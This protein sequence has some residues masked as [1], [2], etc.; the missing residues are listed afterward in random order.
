M[1]YD[2]NCL[3]G[4][5]EVTL[6]FGRRRRI[7]DLWRDFEDQRAVVAADEE[8][9]SP[10]ELFTTNDAETV[11]E[12]T[13][14]TGDTVE[15]TADHPFATPSGMCDLDEV[16]RGDSVFVHPF[17]GVADEEPPEFVVLDEDDFADEN[18]QLVRG[19]EE[20]DLLP[21][22]S[23][24]DAF[25]RLLKLVGFHTGDGSF[26]SN[27]SWFYGDPEDLETVAADIEAVGY[28]ASR[29]Y[30][31]DRE[32]EIDGRSFERT[33]YS[34]RATAKGFKRLLTK[35]G[36][37]AGRKTESDF[38][39]PGYLD[40]LA[41]WQKALY[42]SAFF[43]AEMS[44]PD[45]MTAKNLYCPSVSHNR[46]VE[47]AAAGEAFVS[48][49]MRHLN[50]LGVRTN[51]L[52]TVERTETTRGETVR[53]RFGVK[54]DS[55]NLIRFFTRVGYRYNRVK[56][57]RA[58]L[59]AQYL[60]RKE[61]VVDE[62]ARLAEEARALADGG[63]A[64]REVKSRLDGVNGRFVERSIYGQREGRPRPPADFPDFE[65][66]AAETRVRPNFTVETTVES[67]TELGEKPVYDIGV[68]HDAH[69]F[70]ADGFVV[71][72]CG[73]RMVRT[74]L[75]Y[76]DVRGK[77]EELVDSLFANVPSGL[78]GGGV[79]EGNMD[80]VEAVLDRGMDWALEHGYAVDDDL[81]HCEDE[82]RRPD[83]RPE[84]VSEKAKN[85]GKNQIGS[86]GSGNHFLEVQR[87][88][89]VFDESVAGAFGLE[90]EQIV[91]LIH[92]GSRGLGHQVC[93][94]YLRRIEREH[95]DLLDRLPDKE[96][97]AAPAGSELAD[98]YYGAMCA[99]IN[100]A[101]VNRQLITHRTRRVF[102]RV[103]AEEWEDLGM[104]LLYDVAHNI[105]KKEVH[106]VDGE[107]RELYVHRK[108]ATRAFPAGRQEVPRAYRDVGQPVI[109]PGSMGAGSYVLVGGERSM[110]ETFGSTAHG[111]GRT[112][113]R[114]QAKQEYWGETVRD[115]LES[116]NAIYVKA[117]SGAT[118]AEEAPGVYKDVD[119]VV[120]VSD[121][122]GIGDKVV[123]TYPVCNI[124]G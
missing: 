119:E 121:E 41:D 84:F 79:V 56:R 44:A 65:A 88:T 12:V 5:S 53:Y 27:Q 11:F 74:D 32:H 60:K 97:A 52:E 108:G 81:A 24:D 10:V 2:I 99:A 69:N 51:A 55:E 45:A 113:S 59:A 39:V 66:F 122:L 116:Q 14:E 102:E 94:D 7:G 76:D 29:I 46:A 35:L 43:G 70:V 34:V 57:E 16:E 31:R 50:D 40:R 49:L 110:S 91:V 104:D 26:G 25:H 71:S 64:L 33:E 58:V 67:V 18:P 120:R 4:E 17:V 85:R 92:C 73:V 117:Q 28:T 111:A 77:E 82:G 106:T 95:G 63:L 20:R 96:L 3:S 61:R 54:N 37:P 80:T 6:E 72:N 93:S 87:V 62:R 30:E 112:M 90:E 78:G 101:W 115:E 15:A 103:F 83:A 105:A 89:D 47:Y 8:V 68:A 1:G 23:T 21:L 36:A 48:D 124:K 22:K 100:F 118:V 75:T 86:L 114:T 98:E 123:R 13:T 42:L 107:D 9:T 19:L 109:I 38:G